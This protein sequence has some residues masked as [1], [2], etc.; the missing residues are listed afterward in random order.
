[1]VVRGF[2]RR[3]MRVKQRMTQGDKPSL[4]DLDD[5]LAKYLDF[6]GGFFIEAGANDGFTQSNTYYLEKS[7]GWSGVLIEAVPDL[8][9]QCRRTRKAQV[10]ECALVASTFPDSE[11]TIHVANLMSTVEGALGS[12]DEQSKHLS[13]AVRSQFLDGTEAIQVPARTL[14]SV[15]ESSVGVSTIDFFSL[16]VEGYELDVLKGLDFDRFAPRFLLVEARNPGDVDAFLGDRYEFVE[17][18]SQL[19]RLYRLI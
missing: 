6:D 9:A 11:I 1:M 5:K 15:L 19:D 13:D 10:F 8:A 7:R 3:A 17:Q 2:V 12:P 4:N 16:D 18:M 14:T